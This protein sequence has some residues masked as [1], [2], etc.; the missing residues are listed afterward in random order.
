M[1]SQGCSNARR[2]MANPSTNGGSSRDRLGRHSDGRTAGCP[3]RVGRFGH[4]TTARSTRLDAWPAAV[5]VIG[6]SD[7]ITSESSPRS[8]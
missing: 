6:P 1:L 3:G 8:A 7:T 2:E 5:V 4:R